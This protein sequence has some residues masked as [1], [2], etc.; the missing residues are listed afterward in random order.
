MILTHAKGQAED[1]TQQKPIRDIVLTVPAYFNQAERRSLSRAVELAGLNLLQLMTEPMAVSLN[2]GMFRR[3]EINGTVK[4]LM[5]YDMGAYDTTVS[6]VGY[7]V[8]K[9][10]ERGFSETHPQAQ[11]LG[12]GYDRTL[13]GLELQIKLREHLATK[14]NELKKPKTGQFSL[15]CTLVSSP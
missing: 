7:T 5:F 6:I 11:I 4:H 10:K 15:T 3:K 8:V 14:F 13:G 9:T 1:F 12:L 2:Y